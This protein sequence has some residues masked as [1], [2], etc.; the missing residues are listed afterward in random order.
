MHRESNFKP[1]W[2]LT[3]TRGFDTPEKLAKLKDCLITCGPP[4]E[5]IY[6][7]IGTFHIP[8]RLSGDLIHASDLVASSDNNES[9]NTTIPENDYQFPLTYVLLCLL[10]NYILSKDNLLLKGCSLRN[11]E[12]VYGITIYTGHDTKLMKNMKP[13]K[14]KNGYV[15]TRL[16][17]LLGGLLLIHQLLCILL[18]VMSSIY[19]VCYYN[20]IVI[21]LYIAFHSSRKLVYLSCQQ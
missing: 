5:E 9:K 8:A 12:W 15:E 17:L 18:V 3:E 10:L 21:Y 7:F 2:S 13:R 20:S 4:D 1:R 16:N 11:T 6:R 19:Q 14:R